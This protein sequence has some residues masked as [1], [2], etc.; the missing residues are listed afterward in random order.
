VS[1]Q[2]DVDA[3]GLTAFCRRSGIR[4]LSFFGS[5]LR[6]DF[7]PGSD[8]DVLV[9]FAPDAG[10]GL[11]EFVDLQRELGELL[12]REVDLHTPASLSHFFREDV[13]DS[14]EVA[15]AA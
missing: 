8:I 7:G 13:I 14:A 5:V 4:R 3:E 1:V 12:G 15:Y 9:E 10:V 2:I 6:D 11:F